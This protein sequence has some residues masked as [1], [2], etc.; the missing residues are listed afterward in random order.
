MHAR[1]DV[2]AEEEAQ[3]KREEEEEAARK[4]AEAEDAA[5]KK[6]QTHTYMQMHTLGRKQVCTSVYM[7]TCTDKHI[8]ICMLAHPPRTCTCTCTHM[9]AVHSD[10][11][12]PCR[13]M[14]YHAMPMLWQ[15]CRHAGM[16]T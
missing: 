15:A 16:Q 11:D 13:A 7:C 6:A 1:I 12:M 8:H 9:H 10:R 2:Q 3:R 5:R 4:K 14:P